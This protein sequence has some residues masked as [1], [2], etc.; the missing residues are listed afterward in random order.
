MSRIN[1]KDLFRYKLEEIN[2]SDNIDDKQINSF[3]V[4][5]INL[6]RDEVE[7]NI[8]HSNYVSNFKFKGIFVD[9]LFKYIIL[10]NLSDYI[11]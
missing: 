3:F 5:L 11:E 7:V 4:H 6:I 10:K 9:G 2:K 8:F 1:N